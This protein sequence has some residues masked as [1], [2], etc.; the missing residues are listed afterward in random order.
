LLRE[1]R[2]KS[3]PQMGATRYEPNTI[4]LEFIYPD[5]RSST[6]VL[7]VRLAAPERIVFM[8][9]PTWVIE[10]IWQGEITGS[11]HFESEANRL[12]EAFRADLA[13][14][15]NQKHFGPQSPT[16]RG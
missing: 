5:P 9:V 15:A 3:Q 1:A 6:L 2:G 12:L 14:D 13:E 11:Y 8:S 7:E 16:R 4:V 10:Q